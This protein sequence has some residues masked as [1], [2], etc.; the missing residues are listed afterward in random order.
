MIVVGHGSGSSSPDTIIPA[1][2]ELRRS[3]PGLT[4]E[5]FFDTGEQV[6]YD[7]NAWVTFNPFKADFSTPCEQ[8]ELQ[9]TEELLN[10]VIIG[11]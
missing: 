5:L 9:L 3:K 2:E 1:M 4:L 6:S 11:D 10:P 8:T 7:W